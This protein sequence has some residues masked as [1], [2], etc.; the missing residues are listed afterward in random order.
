M[1]LY[2]RQ[3]THLEPEVHLSPAIYA[4]IGVFALMYWFAI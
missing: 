4:D 1:S 3:A 2:G